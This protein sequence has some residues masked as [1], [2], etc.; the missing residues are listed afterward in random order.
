MIS[1]LH[2]CV[3][4][5]GQER[6]AANDWRILLLDSFRA[7][8]DVRIKDLCM[9][10]GYVVLFHYGHTTG[11]CQVS[12]VGLHKPLRPTYLDIESKQLLERQLADRSMARPT[13]R[14]PQRQA[15]ALKPSGAWRRR[16]GI[17][18]KARDG[19]DLETQP[20]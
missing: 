20:R 10:R 13:R 15:G 12:D 17:H 5:F 4:P 2:Q 11:T 18:A 16:A 8:F 7:H 9:E 19:A 14:L 3:P 6:V 1:F